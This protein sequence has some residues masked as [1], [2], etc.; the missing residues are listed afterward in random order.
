M[1][2][3]RVA[4]DETK[5]GPILDSNRD[6]LRTMQRATVG[7]NGPGDFERWLGITLTEDEKETLIWIWGDLLRL[8]LITPTGKDLV[9]RVTDKGIAA[10]DGKSYVEY[11][12]QEVFIAKGEVY[13]AA[14]AAGRNCVKLASPYAA[15][16]I[17]GSRVDEPARQR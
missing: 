10:I 7:R 2:A 6:A 5:L 12:E 14:K 11:D 16:G 1:V 4:W 3:G 15:S 13:S 8:R 9:V 17:P